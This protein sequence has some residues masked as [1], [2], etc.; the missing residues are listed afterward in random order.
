MAPCRTGSQ[1]IEPGGGRRTYS[2]VWL[3]GQA[4]GIH[5]RK[6]RN[7]GFAA[8]RRHSSASQR[9]LKPG[10]VGSRPQGANGMVGPSKK[11]EARKS[12]RQPGWITLDGG[13]AARPCVVHDISSAGAKITLEEFQRVVRPAPAGIRARRPHRAELRS[14]LAP[15]KVVRRSSSSARLFV[16]TRFLRANRY[17]L[18]SKALWQNRPCRDK[19]RDAKHP[20]RDRGCHAVRLVRSGGTAW[21]TEAESHPEPGEGTAVEARCRPRQFLRGL[22]SGVCE[23]RRQ[24]HLRQGRRQCPSRGGDFTLTRTRA[25]GAMSSAAR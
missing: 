6:A 19:R 12:L 21:P 5:S 16:L 23:S 1:R 25:S 18:R 22:R 17:P 15:G 11:R 13:F 2:G 14:G 8:P 7:A 9:F 24:R 20:A 3:A 4:T 10:E